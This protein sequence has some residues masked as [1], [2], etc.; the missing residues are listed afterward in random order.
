MRKIS[1]MITQGSRVAGLSYEDPHL[2]ISLEHPTPETKPEKWKPMVVH[3]DEF[4]KFL[5]TRAL[6]MPDTTA[7]AISLIICVLKAEGWEYSTTHDHCAQG[8]P[9]LVFIQPADS[10]QAPQGETRFKRAR[11]GKL[12]EGLQG[13][14]FGDPWAGG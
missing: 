11:T 3:F 12:I 14:E 1:E 9:A 8:T 5:N 4:R 13:D 6:E 2:I 10:Q 7:E